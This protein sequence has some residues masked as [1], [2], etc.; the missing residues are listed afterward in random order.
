MA[1][2]EWNAAFG[3]DSFKINFTL[4]RCWLGRDRHCRG[5]IYI[6]CRDAK[7][8]AFSS[9]GA[10]RLVRII[11]IFF[12]DYIS[13]ARELAFVFSFRAFTHGRE[14]GWM[15]VRRP[16]RVDGGR[17]GVFFGTPNDVDRYRYLP[18]I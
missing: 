11:F 14:N 7:D 18:S 10:F 6:I 2:R 4:A 13:Y 17:G 12:Y 3:F 16:S 1:A 5:A 15:G 8:D 9:K